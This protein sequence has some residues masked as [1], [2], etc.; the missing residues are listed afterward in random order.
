VVPSLTWSIVRLVLPGLVAEAADSPVNSSASALKSMSYSGLRRANALGP[1]RRAV[2]RRVRIGT[3]ERRPTA[4]RVGS[5]AQTGRLASCMPTIERRTTLGPPLKWAGGKRWQ[6]PHLRNLWAPHAGRRLVEPFC[7]GLAI[8]LGLRPGR[9]LLNDANPHL[10]NFYRWLQKG[11]RVDLPMTNDER[12]FYEHRDRFN[13]L[14]PP[15][16]G[17]SREAAALF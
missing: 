13:A 17:S 12:L 2:R 7:G 4:G 1:R 9:A 6:V 16:D 15:D 14:L 8:T 3:K 5:D 10:I 11:L